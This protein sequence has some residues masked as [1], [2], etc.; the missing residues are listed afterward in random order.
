MKRREFLEVSAA[1]AGQRASP[2]RSLGARPADRHRA[3]RHDRRGHA[4]VGPL[5]AAIFAAGVTCARRR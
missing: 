1:A 3:L 4:G 2:R 5:G